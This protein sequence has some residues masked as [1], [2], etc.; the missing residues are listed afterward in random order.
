MSQN[1]SQCLDNPDQMYF[2]QNRPLGRFFLLVAM[3]V[4][5]YICLSPPHAICFDAC[6]WPSDHM[7][8]SRPLINQ[9]C[10]FFLKISR[11]LNLFGIVDLSMNSGGQRVGGQLGISKKYILIFLTLQKI[12][13]KLG[14]FKS[15]N[16]EQDPGFENCPYFGT[17]CCL[18]T[19]LCIFLFNFFSC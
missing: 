18:A 6:Y 4:Y 17:I 9:L 5:I 16:V 14:Q 15:L 3:S 1:Q 8:R 7:I 2:P 13:I 11:N 19:L 12:V 10:I